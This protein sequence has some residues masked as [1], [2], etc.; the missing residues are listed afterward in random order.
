MNN[1][2]KVTNSRK[3]IHP[4]R[5]DQ[6]ERGDIVQHVA[7]GSSYVVDNNFGRYAIAVN[8]MHISNPSEW[9]ILKPVPPKE[10]NCLITVTTEKVHEIE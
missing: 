3:W 9:K 5:M 10:L 1:G 4:E 2:F 7:T 8:T 6:F